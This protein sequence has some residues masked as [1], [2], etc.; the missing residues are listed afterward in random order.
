MRE[1][2]SQEWMLSVRSRFGIHLRPNANMAGAAEFILGFGQGN[3]FARIRDAA[4]A[5]KQVCA[6]PRFH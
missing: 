1:Q 3:P 5:G 6:D 4:I 2:L